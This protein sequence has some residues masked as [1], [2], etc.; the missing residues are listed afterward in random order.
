LSKVG[1]AN[2]SSRLNQYPHQL[3][4]GLRQRVMIAMALMCGPKLI[5]ADEPTTALDVTVQAQILKLMKDLQNEFHM[6]LIVVTHDL[7][8]V[9]RIADEV[10]VMYA[11]EIVEAGTALEVLSRPHHPYT[12]GLLSCVPKRGVFGSGTRLGSIPGVVPSLV[13]ES[14]GC[15]FSNR[16]TFAKPQCDVDGI[17]RHVIGTGNFYRCWFT[18]DKRQGTEHGA[19]DHS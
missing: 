12:R 16:C 6:G 3:S 8:V 1:I 9:A 7:G 5:V 15:S 11:G 18:P 4:G 17:P 19:P 10:A 2:A 13:G 14:L